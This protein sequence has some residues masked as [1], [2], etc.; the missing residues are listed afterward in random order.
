MKT[1]LRALFLLS[2]VIFISGGNSTASETCESDIIN[3]SNDIICFFSIDSHEWLKTKNSLEYVKEAQ[4][5]GLTCNI[6]K[7][8]PQNIQ[9]QNFDDDSVFLCESSSDGFQ[10]LFYLSKKGTRGSFNN[11]I[12]ELTRIVDTLLG[13]SINGEAFLKFESNVLKLEPHADFVWSWANCFKLADN[14]VSLL[15]DE[16]NIK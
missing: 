11:Q 14:I 13:P 4:R 9:T 5:R 2:S 1:F 7:E 12:F 15:H 16:K 10:E 3:C 8:S 6:V